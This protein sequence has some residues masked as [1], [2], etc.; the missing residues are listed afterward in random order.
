MPHFKSAELSEKRPYPT[1]T[2][3]PPP[4]YVFP[5]EFT[6]ADIVE[7]QLAVLKDYDTVILVDNSD[8][9][10]PFWEDVSGA[11]P[12]LQI[13]SIPDSRPLLL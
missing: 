5:K 13:E 9:M 12:P 11:F 1:A 8:S 4:P 3:E 10:E 6:E 7:D 2:D